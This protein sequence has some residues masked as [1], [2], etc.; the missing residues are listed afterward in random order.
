MKYALLV[1]WREFA[2]SIKAKGFWI[3]IF[4]MP[5]M[6]F[7]S[8]QAPMWLEQKATPV[9]YYVL[10]DQ[11]GSLAKPI[12]SALEKNYRRRV[13]EALGEYSRKYSAQPSSNPLGLDSDGEANPRAV[14]SFIAKGGKDAALER[15]KPN[16][17]SDAPAF[18]SPRR[19]YQ[20]V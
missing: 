9:R 12:E 5:T 10:V 20:I 16:L 4:L 17:K 3:S 7:F 19:P 2:E 15:L 14:D 18:Q 8:I 1:A 13:L 6:L 11:S